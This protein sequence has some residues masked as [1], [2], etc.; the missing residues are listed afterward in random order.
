MAN[1]KI[2][3]RKYTTD[4]ALEAL[5]TLVKTLEK[6][7]MSDIDT[8]E[9]DYFSAA[10]TV[11]N[12]LYPGDC[13]F[14]TW[15]QSQ[16]FWRIK[17]GHIDLIS[18]DEYNTAVGDAEDQKKQIRSFHKINFQECVD[19]LGKVLKKYNALAQEKDKEIEKFLMVGVI[20]HK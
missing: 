17:G 19:A 3:K 20:T 18:A 12:G 16:A 14:R 15:D 9:S 7:L 11:D 2:E 1:F 10:V 8:V 13:H 5:D 4:K 6:D